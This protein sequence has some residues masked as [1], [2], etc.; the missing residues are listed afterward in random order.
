M[1]V[2]T[3]WLEKLCVRH[4]QVSAAAL[5]NT[6]QG[7]RW[8]EQIGGGVAVE[9][10]QIFHPS[11]VHCYSRQSLRVEQ[12]RC[13]LAE[14]SFMHL[15]PCD[16]LERV[17]AMAE[18]CTV[19]EVSAHHLEVRLLKDRCSSTIDALVPICWMEVGGSRFGRD[20]RRF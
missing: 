16:S 20:G 14:P 11:G 10:K 1:S 9:R 17:P 5:G 8:R 7:A 2:A 13:A 4:L 15:V 3:R 6:C 18:Q 12:A 19:Y